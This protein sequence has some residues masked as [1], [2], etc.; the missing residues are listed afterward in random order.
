MPIRATRPD[1]PTADSNGKA[2]D[3]EHLPEEAMAIDEK[4]PILE[5]PIDSLTDRSRGGDLAPVMPDQPVEIMPCLAKDMPPSIW[6]IPR[7]PGQNGTVPQTTLR[8][9]TR[10]CR[11][12]A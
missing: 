10:G 11:S 12:A 9:M 7:P 3:I 5:Y 6:I 4:G 8:C 1:H 2:P